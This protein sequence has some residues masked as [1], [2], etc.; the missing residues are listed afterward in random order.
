MPAVQQP[1]HKRFP[2]SGP[3]DPP[4]PEEEAKPLGVNKLKS[5]IRQTRRLLA[6][7]RV[8]PDVRVEKERRLA[9]LE[10]DLQNLERARMEAQRASRYHHVKFFGPSKPL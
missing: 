2:D 10:L 1:R 3:Y 4:A 6:G 5:Q 7:D 9:A 8:A